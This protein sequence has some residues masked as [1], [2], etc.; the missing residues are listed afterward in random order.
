MDD[1]GIRYLSRRDVERLAVSASEIADRL[2][3]LLIAERAGGA[4][5][6]PKA[7]IA[8]GDG[9]LSLA[10]LSAAR[11]AVAHGAQDGRRLARER[12]ARSPSHRAGSS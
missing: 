5:E 7:S 12:G 8:P 4:W 11:A 2:E 9:R 1:G 10:L 6:A 3:T